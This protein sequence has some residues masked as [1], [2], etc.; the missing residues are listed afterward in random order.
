MSQRAVTVY[1][2][3]SLLESLVYTKERNVD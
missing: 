1:R 3:Q 2:I